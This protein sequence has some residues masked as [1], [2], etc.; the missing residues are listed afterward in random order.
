MENKQTGDEADFA[1][2]RSVWTDQPAGAAHRRADENSSDFVVDVRDREIAPSR[3]MVPVE[4]D[5]RAR[6]TPLRGGGP[7]PATSLADFFVDKKIIKRI[8]VNRIKMAARRHESEFLTSMLASQSASEFPVVET[9]LP[10][11]PGRKQW[12]HYRPYKNQRGQITKSLDFLSLVNGTIRLRKKHP[13]LAWNKNLE[14]KIKAIRSRVFEADFSFLQPTIR[15][16]LKKD[17]AYRAIALF[18]EDDKIIISLT[19]KYFQKQLDFL[20][21]N[22]CL[23]FRMQN[24]DPRMLALRHIDEFRQRHRAGTIYVANADMMSCFNTISHRVA[25]GQLETLIKAANITLDPKALEV[26]RA[27]LDVYSFP[28][29][30]LSA[31]Q[32][33]RDKK[34]PLAFFPWP[35]DQLHKF[36]DDPMSA[37][38]GIPQGGALSL[39]IANVML[40]AA[41]IVVE[42]FR[43]Q[44]NDLLY[45]RFIDDVI[46]LSPSREITAHAFRIFQEQLRL[47]KLPVHAPTN[48]PP[49]RAEGRKIYREVKSRAPFAWG[50]NIDAG[51]IPVLSFLGYEMFRDGFVRIRR[52][53]IEKHK[54]KIT[55]IVGQAV[56]PL[57]E[58]IQTGSKQALRVSVRSYVTKTHGKVIAS[59]VGRVKLAKEIAG[60]LPRSF[61]AG[62]RFLVGKRFPLKLFREL[63]RHRERNIRRLKRVAAKVSPQEIK[64]KKKMLRVRIPRFFGRPYSYLAQFYFPKKRLRRNNLSKQSTTD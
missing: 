19:A 37:N 10:L 25:Y 13:N 62:F 44:G 38:I 54:N 27:Y 49:Y 26:L 14:A 41:D 61:A 34:G 17:H 39:V 6:T 57:N 4:K 24:R 22:S 48:L 5:K 45:F 23:A 56:R 2:Q 40:Y 31:E 20:L 64:G 7:S 32:E 63:D 47:L 43:L 28:H 50:N 46:F 36:H 8:C 3:H 16:K 60:P 21:P 18:C 59:A 29:N 42:H 58:A 11:L 33:L 30:V 35:L 51:E 53:S 9:S 1:A 15:P 52:S 12:R 55:A